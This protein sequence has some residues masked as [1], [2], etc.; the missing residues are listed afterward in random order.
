MKSFLVR[1]LLLG[2][3]VGLL[4]LIGELALR[5]IPNDYSFKRAYLDDNASDLNTLV[6][7]SS[8][9]YRGINPK[10]LEQPAFNA[11]MVSQSLDYDLKILEKYESNLHNLETIILPISYH[12]LFSS[13]KTGVENWRAP[14]YN[15]YY[16]IGNPLKFEIL[17]RKG[18]SSLLKMFDFY[19]LDVK[20]IKTDS[21]GWSPRSLKVDVEE[22]NSSGIKAAQRHTKDNF[23]LFQ[24]ENLNKI[25]A[26]ANRNNWKLVLVTFPV[27][28]S[29]I[30]NLNKEQ[31]K[32]AIY[33]C[34]EM[35]KLNDNVIYF[36]LINA[37]TFN[38]IDFY[39]AD[40][41]NKDGANK[42]SR[43]LNNKLQS[44]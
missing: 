29:Y 19:F 20:F 2:F 9:S 39:D 15:I 24:L 34:Q 35:A 11:A 1:V 40:H 41:L 23:D 8:H 22:L 21:L 4:L 6:L 14:Y 30:E 26:L 13:L 7:G 27:Y 33:Q 17:S 12:S 36:N 16:K 3:P 43:L 37:D 38:A 18:S 42:L 44:P 28:G 5:N 32:L 31:L 10:F 25:N